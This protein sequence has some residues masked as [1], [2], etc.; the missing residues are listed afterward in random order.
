MSYFDVGDTELIA[1]EGYSG[2]GALYAPTGLGVSWSDVTGLAKGALNFYGQA[3]SSAGAAKA[4]QEIA[5]AQAQAAAAQRQQQQASSG[6]M[7]KYLVP[8]LIGGAGLVVLLV[9]L[10]KK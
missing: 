10:K 8:A 3:Q 5:L 2:T 1:R 7:K 9:V 6:G 4:S